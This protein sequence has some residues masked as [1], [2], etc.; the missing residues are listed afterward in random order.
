ML[1]GC[2]VARGKLGVMFLIVCL[3]W[4][5]GY[6]FVV[7]SLIICCFYFVVFGFVYVGLLWFLLECLRDCL[8]CIYLDECLIVAYTQVII[9]VCAISYNVLVF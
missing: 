6:W 1:A 8:V 2:F 9:I 3:G 5:F 4:L 7:Y